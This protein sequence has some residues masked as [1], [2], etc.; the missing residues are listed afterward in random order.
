MSIVEPKK[1]LPQRSPRWWQYRLRTLL[2]LFPVVALATT[3]YLSYESIPYTIS[4]R[5]DDTV[6]STSRF[7]IVVQGVKYCG[8]NPMRAH[9]QTGGLWGEASRIHF[10]RGTSQYP[11]SVMILQTYSWGRLRFQI[12]DSSFS[13]DHS[14]RDVR[15]TDQSYVIR[16]KAS[17][18][19]DQQGTLHVEDLPPHD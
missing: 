15:T 4:G 5:G 14:G 16:Q 6:I 19:I 8:G 7:E 11:P 17:I 2:L 18:T 13:I 3:L 9:F 1:E 10:Y 12:N